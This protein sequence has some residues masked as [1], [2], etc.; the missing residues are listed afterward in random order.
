MVTKP[1]SFRKAVLKQIAVIPVLVIAFILFSTK[2]IAQ[3]SSNMAKTQKVEVPSTKTGI[4]QEQLSEYKEIVDKTKNSQGAYLI[5]KL[6]ETDKNRLQT[7]F[8]SMSK[9]QQEQQTVTFMHPSPPLPKSVPTQEEMEKWKNAN[10][11]GIW[12]D[13]KRAQNSALN[14]FNL[15]DFDQVF[16]SKLTKNAINYGKHYYQVDLMTKEYYTNYCKQAIQNAQKYY[17][18][19]HH[20]E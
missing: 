1:K 16:V 2:I 20:R 15:T 17:I 10:V 3:D 18:V 4:T 8:F 7:L 9:E 12:I 6:S 5:S 19:V 11:Y 14:Q 13:G